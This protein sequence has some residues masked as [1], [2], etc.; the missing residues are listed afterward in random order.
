[1]ESYIP[2]SFLND[3]N[4]CPRSIYNHQLYKNFYS[5]NYKAAP[6]LWGSA[7]H[8]SIENQTYSNSTDWLMGFDVFSVEL[9]LCGKIDLYNKKTKTLRERKRLITRIYDGYYF[10]LYAQFV[11]LEE[12]GYRVHKMELYDI[13]KNKMHPIALP[14]KNPAMNKK[15]YLILQKLKAFDLNAPFTPEKLKCK[16]CIYAQ[17]CDKSLC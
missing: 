11:C 9:N 3:F 6:Q 17:L 10:Q 16:A 14:N 5:H 8:E 7:S 4:F 13:K 12:M 15:F 1:M 2:I